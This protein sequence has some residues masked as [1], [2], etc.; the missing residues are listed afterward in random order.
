MR[1]GVDA[2]AELAP[3]SSRQVVNAVASVT[4]FNPVDL[5]RSESHSNDGDNHTNN[6]V[7]FNLECVCCGMRHSNV[8]AIVQYI[9]Q[10]GLF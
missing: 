3:D 9:S 10:R 5:K 6:M 7:A 8:G 2:R 4:P 1:F